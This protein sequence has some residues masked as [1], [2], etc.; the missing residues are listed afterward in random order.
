MEATGVLA[1]V[2]VVIANGVLVL[3]VDQ[4]PTWWVFVS[5][6]GFS[7]Q[8]PNAETVIGELTWNSQPSVLF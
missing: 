5:P 2:I 6:A 3:D 7:S 4:S 8:K 1:L